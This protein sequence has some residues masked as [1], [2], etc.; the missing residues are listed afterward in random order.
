M[1]SL[2]LMIA[3][4]ILIISC[5][6]NQEQKSNFKILKQD[7]ILDSWKDTI[8]SDPMKPLRETMHETCWGSNN[9]TTNFSTFWIQNDTLY[10]N[11]SRECVARHNLVYKDTFINV[12]WLSGYGCKYKMPIH[13]NLRT[14]APKKGE[15]FAR[16]FLINSNTIQIQYLYPYWVKKF[17]KIKKYN[18]FGEYLD[19]GP[20][21]PDTLYLQSDG[22]ECWS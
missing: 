4:V 3:L 18:V 15:I 6:G 21:F 10:I 16:I 8:I 20:S 14:K 19:F 22:W 17:N 12:Y 7:A 11:F 1:R 5:Y 2:I 9:D 13:N